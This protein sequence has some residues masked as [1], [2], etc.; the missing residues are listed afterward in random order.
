MCVETIAASDVKTLSPSQITRGG[1]EREASTPDEEVWPAGRSLGGGGDGPCFGECRLSR[2]TTLHSGG[3]GGGSTRY[4]SAVSF[5]YRGLYFGPKTI[6]PLPVS[7]RHTPPLP[8]DTCIFTLHR[9]LLPGITPFWILFFFIFSIFLSLS[10][11]PSFLFRSLPVIPP[12]TSTDT[13]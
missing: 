11:F 5:W 6:S 3:G 8:A 7:K 2:D 10:H 12:T 13:L 4:L 1:A 9:P